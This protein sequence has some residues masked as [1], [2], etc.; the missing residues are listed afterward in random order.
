MAFM[1]S[2]V[3]EGLIGRGSLM[4]TVATSSMGL[5]VLTSAT[6]KAACEDV[7]GMEVSLPLLLLF[8]ILYLLNIL[9]SSDDLLWVDWITTNQN[10]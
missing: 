10:F 7:G 5:M 1:G 3:L 9:C 2:S 6:A 4:R 8:L